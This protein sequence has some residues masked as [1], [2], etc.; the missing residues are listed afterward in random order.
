MFILIADAL[1]H[2]K[3]N[4]K[5]Y[6]NPLNASGTQ[7]QNYNQTY[8][9]TDNAKRGFFKENTFPEASRTISAMYDNSFNESW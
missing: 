2:P 9:F 7:R 5:S 4:V 1:S 3:Y 8:L 6:F